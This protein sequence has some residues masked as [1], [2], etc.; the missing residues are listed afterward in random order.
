MTA[1]SIA[2]NT[3]QETIRHN[4]VMELLERRKREIEHN[5]YVANERA[6]R[7]EALYKKLG[8][9]E[10]KANNIALR[11]EQHRWNTMLG[12]IQMAQAGEQARHNREMEYDASEKRSLNWWLATIQE[13]AQQTAEARL[14]EDTRHN[15]NT[16]AIAR[17]DYY[18]R[19]RS[20]RAHEDLTKY[21][22]DTN[23][24][25]VVDQVGASMYNANVNLDI[26]QLQAETSRLN[27]E[28]QAETS[29]HNA[30]VAADASRYSASV[31]ANASMYVANSNNEASHYSTDQR[32]VTDSTDNY[33]KGRGQDLKEK[34][35]NLQTPGSWLSTWNGILRSVVPLVGIFAQ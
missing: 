20:N 21:Q 26:A 16:E 15:L 18:E 5:I 4:G 24:Q 9:E 28:L 1:N 29:R 31:N 2:Y 30:D 12:Q 19:M 3:L 23:R 34:E 35:A 33:I 27:A 11:D 8:Y 25:N 10:T 14:R 6:Q 7:V 32:F 17:G 13:R 22:V